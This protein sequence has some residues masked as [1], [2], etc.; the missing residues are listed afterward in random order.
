MYP[1]LPPDTRSNQA[2]AALLYPDD[3]AAGVWYLVLGL[4]VMILKGDQK[5]FGLGYLSLG[6]HSNVD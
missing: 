4:N 2:V 5:D 6:M 3:R 1:S